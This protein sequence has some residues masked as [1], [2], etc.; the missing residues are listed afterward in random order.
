MNNVTEIPIQGLCTF[1]TMSKCEVLFNIAIAFDR[2][3]Q[4]QLAQETLSSCTKY[5]NNAKQKVAVGRA[6]IKGLEVMNN[7]LFNLIFF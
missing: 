1:W 5:M 3:K 4:E 7:F 2:N 6:T